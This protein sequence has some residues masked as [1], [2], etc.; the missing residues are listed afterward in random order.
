MKINPYLMFDGQCEAAFKFYE[1]ALGGSIVAMMKYGETP[2]AQMPA[3]MS[4]QIIHARLMVGDQVLM[5]ADAPAARYEA[6]K[7][8]SVTLSIEE[9]GEAE[10]VF[11]ALAAGGT[12][13]MP[14]GETFWAQRF[15]MLLDRFGKQ[16]M[17]NCEKPM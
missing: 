17:V 13:T 3:E 6:M 1:Q 9:P 7:G 2:A 8:V 11:H 5:G 16:W 10:R 15:G 4:D 12:V 14:I